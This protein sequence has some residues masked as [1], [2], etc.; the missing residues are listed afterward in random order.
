MSYLAGR[1]KGLGGR[2]VVDAEL[3]NIQ[4]EDG[5]T[6]LLLGSMAANQEI[7][8]YIKHLNVVCLV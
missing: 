2:L 6:A 8:L 7:G 5:Q 1:G 3:I 4:N